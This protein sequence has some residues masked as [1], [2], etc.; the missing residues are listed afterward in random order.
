MQILS[1]ILSMT[2]PFPSMLILISFP[3][4]IERNS[5]LVNWAPWS[6]LKYSGQPLSRAYFKSLT[7]KL[8]L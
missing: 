2:R 4:S 8:R 7:A 5:K 3:W 6:V 1:K